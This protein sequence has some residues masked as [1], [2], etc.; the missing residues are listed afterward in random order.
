MT[1][2]VPNAQLAVIPQNVVSDLF[3]EVA[4]NLQVI[5]NSTYASEVAAAIELIVRQF[6]SGKKLLVFGNGGSAADAQHICAELVGRFM[7]ERR[8]LPA[9]ALSSNIIFS[10]DELKQ[11]EM[12]VAGFDHDTLRYFIGDVPGP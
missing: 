2:L 4:T 1:V 3:R 7:K 10:R 11:H 12:R 8:G 5:S 9:I 6:R